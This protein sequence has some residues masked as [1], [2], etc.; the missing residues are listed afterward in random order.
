MPL[1]GFRL[2]C[3][4]AD[5]SIH[6]RR[7]GSVLLLFQTRFSLDYP[8]DLPFV[9]VFVFV[10]LQGRLSLFL[11][12]KFSSYVHGS[13]HLQGYYFL[14]CLT[15]DSQVFIEDFGCAYVLISQGGQLLHRATLWHRLRIDQTARQGQT[16]T[17]RVHGVLIKL[18]VQLLYRWIERRQVILHGLEFV[19]RSDL[20]F[21]HRVIVKLLLIEDAN[22][23]AL[24]Q[25]WLCN[26]IN[27]YLFNP[28][29]RRRRCIK[30]LLE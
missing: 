23:T 14:I 25:I 18:L 3:L 13:W 16:D 9:V 10:T 7:D 5:Q 17:G 21:N 6:V 19:R 30:S 29:I 4:H 24:I 26:T 12:R 20:P 8:K 1:L 11:C 22:A 28:L 15:V 27:S 2:V